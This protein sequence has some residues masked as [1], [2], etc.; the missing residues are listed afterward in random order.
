[1]L[2]FFAS[3]VVIYLL[4]LLFQKAPTIVVLLI[5]TVGTLRFAPSLGMIIFGALGAYL[6][7][8]LICGFL[9]SFSK[10]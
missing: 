7:F 4:F 2:A 10:G 1:M 5:I 8:K 6:V 9:G 3:I